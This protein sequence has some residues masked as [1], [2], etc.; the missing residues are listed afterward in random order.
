MTAGISRDSLL[1][2]F[3]W[4][5]VYF[6]RIQIPDAMLTLTIIGACGHVCAYLTRE[7]TRSG[8]AAII[9]VLFGTGLLLKGLIAI[10]F[11]IARRL[12]MTAHAPIFDWTTWKRFDLW[13]GARLIALPLPHPGTF[14]RRHRQSP[15]FAFSMHSGPG[16]CRGFFWFYFFNEH[17]LRF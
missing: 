11:P 13:L 9:G 15:T 17:L 4:A 7:D 1:S 16:E 12:F 2:N 6:T 10:V 14:S 5:C 8:W 3:R